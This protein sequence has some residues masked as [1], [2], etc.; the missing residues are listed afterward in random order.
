MFRDKRKI[1]L[2]ATSALISAFAG[3]IIMFLV[4]VFAIIPEGSSLSADGIRILYHDH[5]EFYLLN[6]LPLLFGLAGA[7]FGGKISDLKQKSENRIFSYKSTL[8]RTV[9]FVRRIEKKDLNTPFIAVN[10]EKLLE[11]ALES[12]RKSLISTALKE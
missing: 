9:E 6:L 5:N 8:D 7:F 11:T 3:L 4:I 1:K 10:G 12:M 2:I